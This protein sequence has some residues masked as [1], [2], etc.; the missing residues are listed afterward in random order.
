MAKSHPPPEYVVAGGQGRHAEGL[1]R[2][3]RCWWQLTVAGG[4]GA[5]PEDT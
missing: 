1:G 2:R 4:A 3:K 5:A